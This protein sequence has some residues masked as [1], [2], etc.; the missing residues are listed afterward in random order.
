MILHHVYLGYSRSVW[1]ADTLAELPLTRTI[2]SGYSDFAN[3]FFGINYKMFF[4]SVIFE[5]S[6]GYFRLQLHQSRVFGGQ[7]HSVYLCWMRCVKGFRSIPL[8]LG[9]DET[10]DFSDEKTRK[11]KTRLKFPIFEIL[12]GRIGDFYVGARKKTYLFLTSKSEI[13]TRFKVL[14]KKFPGRPSIGPK[15]FFH[16]YEISNTHQGPCGIDSRYFNEYFHV[17]KKNFFFWTLLANFFFLGVLRTQ[18][19]AP[20]WHLE[21]IWKNFEKKNFQKM[22][23]IWK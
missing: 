20:E 6:N 16:T 1:G 13:Y 19:E 3:N 4:F 8:A 12:T 5:K 14:E 11:I 15:L 2:D 17:V 22:F 23:K 7:S 18:I 21:K 10:M 9:P